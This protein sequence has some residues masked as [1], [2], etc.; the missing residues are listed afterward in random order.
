MG[1]CTWGTYG[2]RQEI[3]AR[4]VV[5]VH[6]LEQVRVRE[7]L[8]CVT[9]GPRLE[10]LDGACR[11]RGS[12]WAGTRTWATS[13]ASPGAVHMPRKKGAS[14]LVKSRRRFFW[15]TRP[16]LLLIVSQSCELSCAT[17]SSL[18]DR[19]YRVRTANN[20]TAGRGGGGGPGRGLGAAPEPRALSG[21]AGRA[22]Y[23]ATS[24]SA[25]SCAVA[26]VGVAVTGK[27][28]TLLVKPL[29]SA[30]A[31]GRKTPSPRSHLQLGCGV[32]GVGE[33]TEAWQRFSSE[34]WEGKGPQARKHA[35]IRGRRSA[36]R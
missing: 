17:C 1:R 9:I 30:S 22:T 26:G 2:G 16:L 18:F 32:G 7:H 21:F 8:V 24:A 12:R 15:R 31:E 13:L 27:R 19:A 35:S 34:R 29:P 6:R 14:S 23:R 33:R 5:D 10:T 28:A 4:L 3:K 11:C 20:K 25:M 36:G